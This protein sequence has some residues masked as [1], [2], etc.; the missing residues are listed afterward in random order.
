[1][2]KDYNKLEDWIFVD[3]KHE[4]RQILWNFFESPDIED[5]VPDDSGDYLIKLRQGDGDY[6]FLDVEKPWHSKMIDVMSRLKLELKSIEGGMPILLDDN[7]DNGE[8]VF[9][10]DWK[11]T[12]WMVIIHKDEEPDKERFQE[13]LI[14]TRDGKNTLSQYGWKPYIEEGQ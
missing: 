4:S 6:A 3:G 5:Y 8:V 2:N 7:V 10:N 9:T 1:M 11:I 13:I 14:W 12:T